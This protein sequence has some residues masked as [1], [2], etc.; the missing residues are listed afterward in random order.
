MSSKKFNAKAIV[1]GRQNFNEA[2]KFVDLMTENQGKQRC[3]AKGIRKINS[4]RLGSLELSN[5]VKATLYQGKSFG[6]ITEV[7]SLDSDLSFRENE[8]KLG[9]M[10]YVC[11]LTN[12]LVPESEENNQVYHRLLEARKDV[13]DGKWGRIVEFES[14]LLE[15]LGY[16]LKPSTKRWLGK[17]EFRQAHLELK[18]RIEEIIEHQLTSLKIFK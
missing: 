16:G 4:R 10:M 13:K 8:T 5:W 1:I 6:I 2:D 7:I 15:I 18:S 14:D 3:L 9:T 11:E 12:H 17:G